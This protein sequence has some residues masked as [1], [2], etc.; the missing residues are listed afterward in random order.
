MTETI[1]QETIEDGIALLKLNRPPVNALNP[2]FLNAFEE[3]LAQIEAGSDIRAL[4]I[5][6]NLTVFS[7]GMDL[8][9][10][11]GF[12]TADQTAIVD[13]L[14]AAFARLYGLAKPVIAA[15]NGAAIAGGLFFVLAADYSVARQG[16]KFGLTEVRVGVNFPLAVLDIARDALSPKAF[17]RLLLGGRNVDAETAEKMGIVDEVTAADEVMPRA[18][19]CARDYAA[20][21]PIAYANVKAQMRAGSLRS[22]RDVIDQKSDPARSGWFTEETRQ[23]MVKL[24]QEATRKAQKTVT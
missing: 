15:V 1:I 4:V 22:M 20:I 16:A 9:E 12:S 10:A 3:Q 14:N 7:A 11:Q 23:A 13:G 2:A 21:P 8:K 24:L 17:R 19:V 5:S 18:L 6:S